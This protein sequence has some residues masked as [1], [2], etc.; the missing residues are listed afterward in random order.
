MRMRSDGS[1]GQIGLSDAFYICIMGGGALGGRPPLRGISHVQL[2]HLRGGYTPCLGC[3]PPAP[4]NTYVC[5]ITPSA[6]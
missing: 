2:I 1:S 3:P 6:F 4:H 5:E